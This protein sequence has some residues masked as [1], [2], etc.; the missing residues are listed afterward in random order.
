[1][2]VISDLKKV[3]LPDKNWPVLSYGSIHVHRLLLLKHYQNLSWFC[4]FCWKKLLFQLHLELSLLAAAASEG[5]FIECFKIMLRE[6]LTHKQLDAAHEE[7]GVT[8]VETDTHQSMK[9]FSL[10]M[11]FLEVQ[12][13]C[14][15]SF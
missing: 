7:R 1:M 4:D 13:N 14:K 10:C 5:L 12:C 15:A 3:G 9:S 2:S 11:P 8:K 6:M